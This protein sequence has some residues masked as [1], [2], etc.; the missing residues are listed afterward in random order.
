MSIWRRLRVFTDDSCMLRI[1]TGDEEPD[2]KIR[3]QGGAPAHPVSY[4]GNKDKTFTSQ[5]IEIIC[6]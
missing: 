1:L 2:A 6:C 4:T 3:V 5:T